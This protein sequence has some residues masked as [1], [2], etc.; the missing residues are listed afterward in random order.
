MFNYKVQLVKE[1]DTVLP[2]YY[3]LFMDS[4]TEFPCI[5]YLEISNT[6]E[7]EGDTLRYSS[8]SFRI[9]LWG[10]DYAELTQYIEPLDN[11]MFSLGFTRISYN[12]LVESGMSQLIFTYEGMALEN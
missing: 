2:A 5:T 8:I 12:E 10:E 3:E 4:D 11:L 9:K 7:A 1:L 6:A